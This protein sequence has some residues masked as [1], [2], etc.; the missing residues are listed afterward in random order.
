MN[1]DTRE[2]G[3]NAPD[4]LRRMVLVP[5]NELSRQSDDAVT[6][7]PKVY[8]LRQ[9]TG[10]SPLDYINE[11]RRA[12]KNQEIQ[13]MHG[14]LEAWMLNVTYLR[15]HPKV[16]RPAILQPA[17]VLFMHKIGRK[18]SVL[19]LLCVEMLVAGER[20]LIIINAGSNHDSGHV[21]RGKHAPPT[22]YD[23]FYETIHSQMFADAIETINEVNDAPDTN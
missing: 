8:Y 16:E 23:D 10:K 13:W 4:Q 6:P 11:I 18:R 17:N 15:D 3:L 14:M 21:K 19:R 2:T 12:G 5:Y 22:M 9:A 20:A 7:L 1:D